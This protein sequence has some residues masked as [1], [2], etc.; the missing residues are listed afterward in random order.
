MGILDD[1]PELIETPP[2]RRQKIPPPVSLIGLPLIPEPPR[3][4]CP[5]CGGVNI[6]IT[7]TKKTP[8]GEVFQRYRLCR[9]C[10]LSFVSVP[11]T[12]P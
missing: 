7:G 12:P 8:G 6:K 9:G 10:G 4:R 1:M 5:N 11:A 3:L 2:K